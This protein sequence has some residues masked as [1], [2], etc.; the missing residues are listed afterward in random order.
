MTDVDPQDA[1]LLERQN[2]TLQKKLARVE[3]RVEA[4]EHMQEA[5]ASLMRGLLAELS[6]EKAESERLLLNILP[7]PI[8]ERLKTEPGVIADYFDSVSVLFA[9][10]VG[11]TALISVGVDQMDLHKP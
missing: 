1:S 7:E 10:I 3:G 4:L 11:Y 6:D 9:D 2:R 5:N 8:A